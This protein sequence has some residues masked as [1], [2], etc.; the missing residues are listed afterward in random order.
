MI[1]RPKIT[2]LI[3]AL[4]EARNIVACLESVKWADELFVVDSFSAD[5]T[6]A[7]AAAFP[8][9]PPV[10]VVQ[11]EY[12]NSAAQK[13]WAIPQASHEWVLIVDADERVTPELRDEILATLAAIA[14]PDSAAEPAADGYR[15]TRA[16]TFMGEP[17]NH[18]GW[19]GDDVLR[20]FRRD[21]GRYQDRHVH[22]D[23][24]I[25][26]RVGHLRGKLSHDTMQGFEPY[27]RKFDRYT[28][29]AA[30][31]RAAKTPRVGWTHLALR[32]MARFL[33]QFVLKRGFLDGKVGFMIS[34]MAA[35]SVFMKYAKLWELR[36]REATEKAAAEK[37]LS[38]AR[39]RTPTP[40]ERDEN[41]AV[42]EAAR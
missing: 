9:D 30:L 2:A 13:N 37:S 38:Q 17:V 11:H 32:P 4:N 41:P 31:D 15:I 23:M 19:G 6:P 20:L 8:H 25:D 33:R 34:S 7:L 35:F 39:A 3:P 42:G 18:S 27:M 10:R 26:G 21:K 22:A 14:S 29:W 5:A 16:N 12:V 40:G 1:H 28:S 24:I 36:L